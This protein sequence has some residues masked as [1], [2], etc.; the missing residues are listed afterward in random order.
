MKSTKRR[1]P[2]FPAGVIS[3]VTGASGSSGRSTCHDFGMS[4]AFTVVMLLFL[5]LLGAFVVMAL[6]YHDVT[7]PRKSPRGDDHLPFRTRPV[8][9]ATPK[10]SGVASS[11]RKVGTLTA[12]G[13]ASDPSPASALAFAAAAGPRRCRW[14]G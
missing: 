10:C 6:L 4:P 14:G 7:A 2:G 13:A 8:A 9:Q 5:A 11:S 3:T 1:P 12:A